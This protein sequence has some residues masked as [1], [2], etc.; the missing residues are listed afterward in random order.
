MP[1]AL[2][3]SFIG[4]VPGLRAGMKV[5]VVEHKSDEDE[6]IWETVGVFTSLAKAHFAIEDAK[7]TSHYWADGRW[8]TSEI[9]LDAPIE[10]VV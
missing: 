3:E 2:G 1:E 7:K 8:D 4:R 9:E 10:R 6:P 5:W